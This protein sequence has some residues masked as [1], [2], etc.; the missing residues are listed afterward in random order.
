MTESEFNPIAIYNNL[1]NLR[2]KPQSGNKNANDEAQ[3]ISNLRVDIASVLKEVNRFRACD[4]GTCFYCRE[5]ALF[6]YK[7]NYNIKNQ[8]QNINGNDTETENKKPKETASEVY[9]QCYD[10]INK[11]KEKIASTDEMEISLVDSIA[12]K[13][14]VWIKSPSSLYTPPNL[15]TPVEFDTLHQTVVYSKQE[16]DF[17]NAIEIEKSNLVIQKDSF[18]FLKHISMLQKCDHTRPDWKT[19]SDLDLDRR[20][21]NDRLLKEARKNEEVLAES[22]G[23]VWL[24]VNNFLTSTLQLEESR[25]LIFG[26]GCLAKLSSF[27]KEYQD[28][29]L[30]FNEY[31]APIAEAYK[32]SGKSKKGPTNSANAVDDMDTAFCTYINNARTVISLWEEG[33]VEKTFNNAIQFGEETQRLLTSIIAESKERIVDG[34]VQKFH[35]N[36]ITK[37]NDALRTAKDIKLLISKRVSILRTEITKKNKELVQELE[38]LEDSYKNESQKTL[39]GRLEKAN[40]KE[41]RK[42][43]KKFENA[44]HGSRQY[45]INSIGNLFQVTELTDI[46]TRYLEILMME[47]EMWEAVQ[48]G[49][50]YKNYEETSQKLESQRQQIFKYYYEG[51]ENG[52]NVLSGIIGR[53]FLKEAQRHQ[54]ETLA[55]KK[56]ESFLQSMK[57]ESGKK[58]KGEKDQGQST[59]ELVEP[60]STESS[61]KK[62]KKRKNTVESKLDT[63]NE[64]VKKQLNQQQFLTE[65]IAENGPNDIPKFVNLE[66]ASTSSSQSYSTSKSKPKET[67]GSSQSSNNKP[68]ETTG[69][70][71]SY[72]TSNNKPKETTGSSQSSNNKPKET[73]GS[74]QSYST[75]NN[76]PKET[77]GS[78]QSSNNKPK[79][80]TS[81]SQS[82]ST[83]NNKPKETTSSSQSYSTSNNKPKETTSSSQS[84]STS[85][86]KPKET[87]SSSQSNSTSNNPKVSTE[88]RLS[89]PPGL[90]PPGDTYSPPPSNDHSSLPDENYDASKL[91]LDVLNRSDLIMLVQNL[92]AEKTQLVNTMILM[93]QEV[94][95]MT[96]R[97]ANLADIAR[98]REFQ[99]ETRKQQELEEAKKYIQTLELRISQLEMLNIT[100]NGNSESTSPKSSS[101]PEISSTSQISQQSGFNLF[102]TNRTGPGPLIGSKKYLN[103]WRNPTS[104]TR[105]M[106]C[107]N[108]GDQ[109]HV[110][111]ECTVGCRYCGNS[112]HLS[113]NCD[114]SNYNFEGSGR[115]ENGKRVN[116]DRSDKT[117]DLNVRAFRECALRES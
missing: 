47:G 29:C 105:Q 49:R 97:Y 40:N 84:Y 75:S 87:T 32:K 38:V 13:I 99:I 113:E 46:C 72:S 117:I 96:V 68:K 28:E 36:I 110:S 112:G 104:S 39:Q 59:T 106:R 43:I 1:V 11:Y 107:G 62:K 64:D 37:C 6:I 73:T 81:S 102:P 22:L 31:W 74:S 67:T 82:Y 103:P 7:K 52:R 86:N 17:L 44:I 5:W 115:E 19:P 21:F 2:I 8:G 35:N 83:S 18:H 88:R 85:N 66:T 30:P 45:V 63:P 70:S 14:F 61:K 100:S 53:L 50:N 71:Q 34:R 42:R 92:S 54:D 56:Q 58:K 90:S 94:K 91:N 93:Q 78:S 116:T 51:I 60:G 114:S 25:D 80:T 109:G 48:L 89:I 95:A 65:M 69:S 98:D 76:K 26:K 77:T 111:Q 79:E 23:Q 9:Q 108:C 15:F 20:V 16:N 3:L 41:F 4:A 33:F 55:L 12:Q 27:L 57:Q 10:L 24:Y 101:S